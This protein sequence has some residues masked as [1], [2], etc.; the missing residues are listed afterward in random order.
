MDPD[1]TIDHGAPLT[2]YKQLAGII[3]ARI[4]RGDWTPGR[5]IPAE[6]RLASEYGVARTTVHRAI[7]MLVADGVLFVVPGRGT[8]VAEEDGGPEAT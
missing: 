5:A 6:E 4:D 2:P 1:A 7:R 8:Y 3:V